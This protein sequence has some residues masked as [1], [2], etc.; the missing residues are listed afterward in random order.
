MPHS[1]SLVQRFK[2]EQ[3]NAELYIQPQRIK[4]FATLKQ[5]WQLARG[6]RTTLICAFMACLMINT[7]VSMVLALVFPNDLL[8][9][10]LHLL[11]IASKI[12]VQIF[13]T[14]PL[15]IGS[16]M[17]G[18]QRAR[19]NNITLKQ[20]FAYLHKPIFWQITQWILWLLLIALTV[21]LVFIGI[22]L[23]VNMREIISLI[24]H[25]FSFGTIADTMIPNSFWVMGVLWIITVFYLW[26]A[27]IYS[28]PLIADKRLQAGFALTVSRKAFNRN[29]L[30][31]MA[32]SSISLLLV[33]ACFVV[34]FLLSKPFNLAVIGILSLVAAIVIMPW[35]SIANGLIYH[36]MIKSPESNHQ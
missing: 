7:C 29:C 33:I 23:L 28:L 24:M 3:Q 31:I 6:A 19:G 15:M 17:L 16:L 9:G 1:I 21:G 13:I 11:S 27:Y 20:V 8:Q 5:A 26:W 12:V 30:P 35:L 10:W 32:I 25:Y 18:I 36:H 22:L 14:Y 34:L 4:V 2:N